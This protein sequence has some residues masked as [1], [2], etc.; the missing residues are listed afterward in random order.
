MTVLDMA[1]VH[2]RTAAGI[3]QITASLYSA[4]VSLLKFQDSL[5]EMTGI[6]LK[7]AD[8]FLVGRLVSLCRRKI[9][10]IRNRS[11]LYRSRARKDRLR[12]DM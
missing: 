3:C 4:M 8:I 9:L 1:D 10:D 2:H 12:R 5:S 11:D 6:F 7:A